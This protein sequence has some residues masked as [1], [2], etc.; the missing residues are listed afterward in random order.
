MLIFIN[1]QHKPLSAQGG[2]IP[3][4]KTKPISRL[5]KILKGLNT[6]DCTSRKTQK[7]AACA[8]FKS[9]MRSQFDV[10]HCGTSLIFFCSGML[11]LKFL[12][13]MKLLVLI[14]DFSFI[15]AHNAIAHA[16]QACKDSLGPRHRAKVPGLVRG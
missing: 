3:P 5:S 4:T 7:I 10:V 14:S 9:D 8:G 11:D 15:N 6:F 2:N 1:N 12:K 16:P 13:G